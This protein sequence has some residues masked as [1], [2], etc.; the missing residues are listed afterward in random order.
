MQALMYGI[1]P[2]YKYQD[3]EQ[4]MAHHHNPN[5]PL[6]LDAVTLHEFKHNKEIL[7]LNIR[8]ADLL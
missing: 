6:R 8:I 1:E 4:S 7:R 5:I 3:I 2:D